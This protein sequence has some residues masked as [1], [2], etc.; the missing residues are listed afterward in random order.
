[1]T[2][3]VWR[4]LSQDLKYLTTTKVFL[5][6]IL[7]S[8]VLFFFLPDTAEAHRPAFPDGS[9]KSST[10]AF[11]L[12]DIDISQA[13]YQIL[14]KDEQIWLSFD[15]KDSSIKT[16]IIQLGIPV[17]EE[18]KSFRPMVAV[19]SKKLDK[20]DLPF[21]IPDGF[22]AVL[23]ETNSSQNIKNF[24]EPFTNTDSWILIEDKFEIT[25]TDIHYIVI[26][27]KT[28]QTGKFWFATGTREVFGFSVIADLNKNISKVKTFHKPSMISNVNPLIE[29]EEST[30]QTRLTNIDYLKYSSIFLVTGLILLLL[31]FVS[32]K[33]RIKSK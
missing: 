30:L 2:S 7:I 23:Y 16:L 24:H 25:E 18:T 3:V 27:S 21:D 11:E 26:F 4:N 14:H 10:N 13:I 33:K 31:I 8:I 19:V 17:L 1:M 5:R 15:P 22:G 6:L 12:D 28:N 32:V 9:N 29:T 20:V